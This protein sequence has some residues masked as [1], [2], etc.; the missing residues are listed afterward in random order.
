MLLFQQTNYKNSCFLKLLGQIALCLL[1][2]AYGATSFSQSHEE[3]PESMDTQLR[4]AKIY[5]SPEER[6]EAGLGTEL[7]DWLTFSGLIEI[8]KEYK[9]DNYSGNLEVTENERAT[10]AIQLGLNFVIAEWIEAEF[11]FEA[12][13]QK[14]YFSQMEEGLIAI[15]LDDWGIKAGRQYLPFG[16]YYSHF[17]IGPMLEF[18]ETR[19]DSL[20]VDYSFNDNLEIAAYIFDS[21]ANPDNQNSDYDWGVSVEFETTNEAIRIGA[22]YLS[23]LAETDEPLLE[24]FD[25]AYKRRVSGVSAYA[26][27]G[28]ESFEVTAE[29]VLANRSFSELDSNANKPFSYNLELAY[30]PSATVELALRVEHSREF[31]D[32]PRWKYGIATT[33]R[34]GRNLTL[35]LCYLYADYKSGFVIDDDDNE[36]GHGAEIAGQVAL[37]F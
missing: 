29:M 25:E 4:P 33:W 9:K 24:D 26:L 23:D 21:D 13:N 8:E 7:T 17:I 18:G 1:A 16:E 22:S 10:Q 37:E 30:Y 5:R 34:P 14:T 28:M 2:F 32:N 20:I 27:F 35:S 3:L 11:V 31:K 36:L 12:E 6:R 19:K 15:E